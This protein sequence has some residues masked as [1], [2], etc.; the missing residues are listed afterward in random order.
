MKCLVTGAGGYIGNA[1]VKR[2][3]KEKY[4]VVGFIHESIPTEP[5]PAINY[6]KGDISDYNS[7]KNIVKNIDIIFH[8][9]AFVKDYGQEE[10]FYNINYK[11]T[12]NIVLACKFANIGRF[13]YLSR[14][15]YENRLKKNFYVKSKAL[16]EKFLLDK[17]KSE[18]FPVVIIRPGNVYGPGAKIWVLKPLK[19]IQKNRFAF[20][21]KGTGIFLHTYIE[22]LIDAL[23]SS[24]KRPGIIGESIEITDGD[25]SITWNRYFNDL[26][27]ILGCNPIRRNISKESALKIGKIMLI[28]NSIFKIEPWITPTAVDILTNR[29]KISIEK[30]EKLL[31]Y[32]PKVDY[33]EGMEK[34][35][36]WLKNEGYI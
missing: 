1:L 12:K 23:I 24:M 26:S 15:R 36:K 34:I 6:I 33:K 17:Y 11:G 28:L 10:Q 4:N 14:I 7:V 18:K 3:V 16:A 30:A 8:C 2:L 35:K 21:D 29:K 9:A 5:D 27:S 19:S 22:N 13:I 31:N 25:N 32:S 20:I